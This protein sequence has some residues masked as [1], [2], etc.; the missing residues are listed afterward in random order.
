MDDEF[1]H[2]LACY[3]GRVEKFEYNAA[4]GQLVAARQS[5][6]RPAQQQPNPAA[7]EYLAKRRPP[8]KA[9]E[10]LPAPAR[11]LLRRHG[12]FLLAANGRV[13]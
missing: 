11:R 1:H 4:H 3:A 2:L 13:R 8:R 6:P 10:L 12:K 9:L 7:R 5:P